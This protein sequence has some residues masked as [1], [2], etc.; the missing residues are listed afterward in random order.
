M[1]KSTRI[2][3][4]VS[5]LPTLKLLKPATNAAKPLIAHLYVKNWDD[6]GLSTWLSHALGNL[7]IKS[8]ALSKER[9]LTGDEA[10][11]FTYCRQNRAVKDKKVKSLNC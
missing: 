8:E 2:K 4:D 1:I 3:P 10:F 6:V 7:P 9:P 5:F 11:N